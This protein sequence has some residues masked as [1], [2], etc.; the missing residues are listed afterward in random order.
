LAEAHL[1][2]AAIARKREFDWNATVVSSRRAI[3][4]NPTLEQAHFFTAAAYYH[5]GYME[6]SLI[7]LEQGR[8][9]QGPDEIESLRIEALVALFGGRFTATRTLLQEVSRR[10]SQSIGDT[11]L[12]LAYYYTGSTDQGIAMLTNLA[13]HRTAA[14]AARA[15]AALA[16]VLAAEDRAARAREVLAHVVSGDYRDHHVAYSFGAAY[17]QLGD[18]AAAVR[19]LRTAADTG[20]PCLVWFER[21]PLL[22]PL[23]A[24]AAW[25]ELL[26]HVRR[27]RESS[28]SGVER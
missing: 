25:A 9:L 16:G 1:A 27:V 4:L 20:F 7:A 14:T 22:Q 19:W 2:R 8:R 13:S 6:E 18:H 23:R 5:L 3:T 28:L 21:D 12:A 10:S 15:G 26:T 24:G 17:A 11:Y